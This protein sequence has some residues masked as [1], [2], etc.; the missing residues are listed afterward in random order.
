MALNLFSKVLNQPWARAGVILLLGLWCLAPLAGLLREVW[1]HADHAHTE[2]EAH[3]IEVAAGPALVCQHHP[4]GCPA[5]CHC[6]KFA[7]DQA[8]PGNAVPDAG[9]LHEPS[10]VQCTEGKAKVHPA[11]ALVASWH[12]GTPDTLAEITSILAWPAGSDPTLDPH[13][14]PPWHVPRPTSSFA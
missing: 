14:D 5:D 11:P 4:E 6:P 1:E 7:P 8:G 12:P 9:N 13:R 2:V 10:L 3:R